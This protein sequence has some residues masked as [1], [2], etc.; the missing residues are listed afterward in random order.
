MRCPLLCNV[1]RYKLSLRSSF[2]RE[3]INSIMLA[4]ATHSGAPTYNRTK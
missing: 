3:K 1:H 2:P 4:P